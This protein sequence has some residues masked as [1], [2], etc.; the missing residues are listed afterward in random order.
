M[1]I[2]G[3]KL[4]ETSQVDTFEFCE[5]EI[6]IQRIKIFLQ[7]LKLVKV[8]RS[9]RHHC[10]NGHFRPKLAIPGQVDTEEFCD[11][12][13]RIQRVKIPLENWNWSGSLSYCVKTV[14]MAIFVQDWRG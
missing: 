3:Q 10:E 4:D 13:I 8:T 7:N 14:G 11:Y 5:D 9:V 2:F 12:E 1:A 6:R